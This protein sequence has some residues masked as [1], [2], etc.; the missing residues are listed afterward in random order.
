MSYG[1]IPLR[2]ANEK[3]THSHVGVKAINADFNDCF[4][5]ASF[6]KN[7][8]VLKKFGSSLAG[9]NNEHSCFGN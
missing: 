9:F 2:K 6:I 5:A 1:Q 7:Y 4:N 8:N 3:A